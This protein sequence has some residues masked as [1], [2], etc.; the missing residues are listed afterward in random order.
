METSFTIAFKIDLSS[1]SA[2]EPICVAGPLRLAIRMAGRD[3]ALAKYDRN[4]GNYLNFPLQDGSCPVV[5]ATMEG[6][7]VGVPIGLL[8]VPGG[9]HRVLVNLANTHFSISVDGHIDDDML[10]VPAIEDLPYAVEAL[11]PRVKSSEV[12]TPAIPDAIGR[13]PDS[14]PVAG[15]IQYWTPAGHNAWVGDVAPGVFGGRLHVFYLLDRR[16]H[17]S[18]HGAGGHCFAHLSSADLSHWVEHPH[19]VPIEEW[20]ETLGTGTPFEK[21]GRLCLAYGLH[22]DR[23]VKDGNCPIGGTYAV[24]DDGVHFEKTGVIITDAQNPS[25]Y[26]RPAGGF[27]LVTSFGGTKGLFRSD[28]LLDWQLFDGGLPFRGDCPSLFDWHGRRYLLQGFDRMACSPDGSPGSFADWSSEPDAAYDG[29]SVPMVVPW[30]G[31]RRLY[32]GWLQHPAGWGGW[33]VFRELVVHPDGRLGMKWVPEIEPPTPPRTFHVAPGK[34]FECRFSRVGG[35]GDAPPLVLAVDPAMREA[36]FADDTP[37][38]VFGKRSDAQNVK[39]GGLRGVGGA[40]DVR[41]VV[42]Y[43]PK[44]DATIFDAE[45]GGE[46][47]LVCRRTGRYEDA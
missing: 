24:S 38:T 8:D 18:K 22:T 15:S 5:E 19:A 3:D 41:I 36:W 12:F 46:R 27:E 4:R 21:D 28:N 33:L 43:D 26:N 6:L 35:R 7:R 13:V 10:S 16:H 2:D 11:S 30:R 17:A 42:H 45:I 20:W 23:I 32:I 9:V 37:E 40:Y 25:I 39:V 44:A 47:T 1:M 34:S 29:L 14:R 31:D